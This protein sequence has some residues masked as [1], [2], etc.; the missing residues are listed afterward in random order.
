MV[1]QSRTPLAA[2]YSGVEIEVGACEDH[3]ND[4][5]D[6][7][8]EVLVLADAGVSGAEADSVTG[9]GIGLGESPDTGGV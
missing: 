7:E 3:E 9:K 5:R 1:S 6:F 4:D 8:A 2:K